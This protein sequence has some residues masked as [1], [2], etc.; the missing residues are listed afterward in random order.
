MKGLSL[1]VGGFGGWSHTVH[2]SVRFQCLEAG[3]PPPNCVRSGRGSSEPTH[4]GYVP[5]LEELCLF[6]HRQSSYKLLLIMVMYLGPAHISICS[7][8][9]PDFW[10]PGILRTAVPTAGACR[11]GAGFS[12]HSYC[13][14]CPC[15]RVA[16]DMV[17]YSCQ[18]WSVCL[19]HQAAATGGTKPCG[20]RG[21]H[22]HPDVFSPAG[23]RPSR[24]YLG[25]VGGRNARQARMP[26]DLASSE[27][28]AGIYIRSSLS[29]SC[30]LSL[31]CHGAM[32]SLTLITGRLPSPSAP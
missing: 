29:R 11:P 18:R 19:L 21:G 12:L 31:G 8:V 15:L 4:H 14:S 27:F 6:V 26:L 10:A 1:G 13:R 5:A 2:S 32:S 3:E 16:F 23:P 9:P 28:H 17:F 24:G 20:P 7:P 25:N 30:L 22:L